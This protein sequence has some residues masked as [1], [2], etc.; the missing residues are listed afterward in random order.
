MAAAQGN[1]PVVFSEV[2]HAPTPP[3]GSRSLAGTSLAVIR[4]PIRRDAAGRPA[5]PRAL[6]LA[7][8]VH[9]QR[10]ATG[11]LHAPQRLPPSPSLSL[12]HPRPVLAPLA[13]SSPFAHSTLPQVLNLTTA[14]IGSECVKFNSCSMES[15]KFITVCDNTGGSTQVVIVD[16]S[17]GNSVKKRPISA[18]AAIMNPVS[19]VT[20]R[21]S[22]TDTNTGTGTGTGTN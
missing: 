6:R 19:E 2:T 5:S 18:E 10:P 12:V 9:I 17:Q 3:M 14:G 4:M 7:S 16:M 20:H 22:N 11:H 1:I 8:A 13:L 15:D 21:P